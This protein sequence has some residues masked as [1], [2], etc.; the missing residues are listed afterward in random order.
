[1]IV[2]ALLAPLAKGAAIVS[3]ALAATWSVFNAGQRAERAKCDAG[4][5]RAELA[6]AHA[7][8]DAARRAAETAAVLSQKLTDVERKNRELADEA[9]R[10]A[11]SCPLGPDDRRRLLDIR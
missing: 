1:M 6:A 9:A 2:A 10:L 3:F 4:A 7:D 11:K 5:L 8:L